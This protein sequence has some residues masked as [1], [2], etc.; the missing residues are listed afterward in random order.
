MDIQSTIQMSTQ[1]TEYRGNLNVATELCCIG[2]AQLRC[3]RNAPEDAGM[4]TR[5]FGDVASE[6]Q[7][8]TYDM[9]VV[10]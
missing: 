8:R 3:A 1:P 7:M 10:L 2:L 6:L 9:C 4:C 5:Y